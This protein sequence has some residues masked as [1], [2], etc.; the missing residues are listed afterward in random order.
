MKLAPETKVGVFLGAAG[1][2]PRQWPDAQRYDL[3][4]KPTG[5]HLSFGTGMHA[6]IGQMIARL[7]A[8]C[9]LRALLRRLASLEPAGVARFRPINQLRTLD[10][11][12]LALRLV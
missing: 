7:E 10:T 8:E 11:L 5:I 3:R 2:D 4:R 6:C 1:R 9:I 12:P